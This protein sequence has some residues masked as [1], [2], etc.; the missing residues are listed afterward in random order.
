MFEAMILAAAPFITSWLVNKQKQILAI[1]YS[2][3]KKSILRGTAM[4]L[5]FAGVVLAGIVNGDPV[6]GTVI[7]DAV[8]GVLLFMSNQLPYWMGEKKST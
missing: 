4:T 5:S 2:P 7:G 6:T 1:K 8:T 3:R